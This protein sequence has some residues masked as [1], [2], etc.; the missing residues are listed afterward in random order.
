MFFKFQILKRI[1]FWRLKL[2]K[3][4]LIL[5]NLR[6]TMKVFH[7]LLGIV[8]HGVMYSLSHFYDAMEKVL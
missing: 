3:G 4:N 8:D 6:I 5:F 1:L 2:G 7:I